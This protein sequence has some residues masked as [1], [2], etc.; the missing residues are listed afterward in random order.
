VGW[1]EDAA[2]AFQLYK[3]DLASATWLAHPI[4]NEPAIMR[5]VQ[6]STSSTADNCS[7]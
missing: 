3:S 7:R 6:R 1:S 4:A 5:L 2:K